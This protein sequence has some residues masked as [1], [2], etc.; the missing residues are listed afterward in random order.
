[1]PRADHRRGGRRAA[2]PG[3]PQCSALAARARCLQASGRLSL[4]PVHSAGRYAPAGP[5]RPRFWPL[6]MRFIPTFP[7]LEGLKSRIRGF[8]AEQPA[9]SRPRVLL[10][11]TWHRAGCCGRGGRTP[12][13]SPAPEGPTGPDLGSSWLFSGTVS[14]SVCWGAVGTQDHMEHGACVSERGKEAAAEP[15]GRWGRGGDGGSGLELPS[16]GLGQLRHPRLRCS[17]ETWGPVCLGPPTLGHPP[18]SPGVETWRPWAETGSCGGAEQNEVEKR[19]DMR[20]KESGGCEKGGAPGTCPRPS[21]CRGHAADRL[22]G[23]QG[24]LLAGGEQLGSYG[25]TTSLPGPR[26]P[27]LWS[28]ALGA[29]PGIALLKLW[30]ACYNPGGQGLGRARPPK[31][32]Q[33]GRCF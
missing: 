24:W 8:L 2:G 10:L 18:G 20:F 30:T 5:D 28:E 22:L 11:G 27:I 26:W 21:L 1:M 32:Q 7:L 13:S 25:S 3:S 33:K 4:G 15:G 6:L 23:P 17:L 9:N 31:T 19:V 16:Q 12:A 29:G 14:F